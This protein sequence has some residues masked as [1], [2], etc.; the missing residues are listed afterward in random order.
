MSQPQ[1]RNLKLF[2]IFTG[3]FVA[4]LLIANV[5]A[6]KIFEVG[7]FTFSGGIIIFPIVYIFGDILTEVYGYTLSRKIIWTGLAC[8]VLAAL[9]YYIVQELPPASFWTGQE[10]F[11]QTFGLV[12]RIVLGSIVAY[13]CGEF[14]NSYILSKMKFWAQGKRGLAQAWRFVASTV[15]GEAVDTVLIGIIAFAGVFTIPQ[16]V[17]LLVS[18]YLFKVVYEI[19][20]TP[21]STRFANWVKKVEEIDQI[22]TPEQTNYNP[23]GVLTK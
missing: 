16:L 23:F 22:D 19:I 8:Q 17:R 5:T 18:V 21:I 15:A 9:C 3:L 10:A 12:P 7:P 4:S 11:A 1:E 20:L 14:V 13:F 6:P 2:S